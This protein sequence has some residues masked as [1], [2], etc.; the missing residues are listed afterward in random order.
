MDFSD[1]MLIGVVFRQIHVP[2]PVPSAE[3]PCP[4]PYVDPIPPNMT[5]VDPRFLGFLAKGQWLR[6][7]GYF[8][9]DLRFHT[10]GRCQTIAIFFA[11]INGELVHGLDKSA[12]V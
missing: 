7:N 1:Y 5:Q 10:L 9:K 2:L 11:H 4:S 12:G 6:A 3:H 8:F